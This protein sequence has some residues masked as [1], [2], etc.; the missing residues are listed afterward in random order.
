MTKYYIL[1]AHLVRL[2]LPAAVVLGRLPGEVRRLLGDLADLERPPRR[3]R[4]PPDVDLDLGGVLAELV[5]GPE[6]VLAAEGPLGRDEHDLGHAGGVRHLVDMSKNERLQNIPNF[7]PPPLVYF[8]LKLIYE[9]M[10]EVQNSSPRRGCIPHVG[11]IWQGVKPPPD[12]DMWQDD[13]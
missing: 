7:R 10:R 3:G 2:D 13:R 1:S 9:T 4:P 12:W 6:D 8:I 11:A 5:L